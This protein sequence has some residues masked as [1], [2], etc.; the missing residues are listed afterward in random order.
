M[1]TLPSPSLRRRL[2]SF[3]P[4]PELAYGLIAFAT[5]LWASSVVIGRGVHTEIPPVGLSF[6]RWGVGAL[7]LLP[8]VLPDLGAKKK[9]IRGHWKLILLLGV[10]QV[11]SSTFIMLAVNFTTALNSAL[12]NGSQPALTAVV[13]WILIR[14]QVTLG[15]SLGIAAGV[16]GIVIIVV[17]ADLEVILGMQLNQGDGYAV[18]AIIGWGIYAVLLHRLPK[19]LGVT[20]TLFLIIAT[21]SLAMLPFYVFESLVFRP[22]PLTAD[23]VGIVVGMAIFISVLSVFVWN[24]G[25][26]S[27]G[28]NRA[29]IFLNLVPVFG[30]VLAVVTLGE[31]LQLFHLAGAVLVCAG[32]SMVIL[33]KR[34]APPS[35]EPNGANQDGDPHK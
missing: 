3:E 18:L 32:I 22:V 29:S 23:V 8:L 10:L 27:V 35:G 26:R 14:D 12:I 6:W 1:T 21:G 15:Q 9:M 30:A 17:R 2:E 20:T 4:S 7:F 11:G 13:A 28:P 24:A 25:V 16:F 34:K 19:E 31:R 5:F 33:F